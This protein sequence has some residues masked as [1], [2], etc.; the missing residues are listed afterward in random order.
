M[1]SIIDQINRPLT[2]A[3][4]MEWLQRQSV[5]SQFERLGATVT[6]EVPS[7]LKGER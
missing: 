5:V 6:R 4:V 7:V 2:V 1:D 3:E